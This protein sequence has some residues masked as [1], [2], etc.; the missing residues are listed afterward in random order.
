MKMLTESKW[1]SAEDLMMLKCRG[2]T[3]IHS[4]KANACKWDCLTER[5]DCSTTMSCSNAICVTRFTQVADC[6]RWRGRIVL[7]IWDWNFQVVSIESPISVTV[8]GLL[9]LKSYLTFT[10]IHWIRALKGSWEKFQDVNETFKIVISVGNGYVKENQ[11]STD[12]ERKKIVTETWKK[13]EEAQRHG[14]IF[15]VYLFHENSI[16]FLADEKRRIFPPQSDVNNNLKSNSARLWL[17]T[18]RC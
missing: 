10:D 9:Q 1:F 3:E 8:T 7:F 12:G 5:S 6:N 2:N 11:T 13:E 18:G 4:G 14:R 16:M 15:K 17:N